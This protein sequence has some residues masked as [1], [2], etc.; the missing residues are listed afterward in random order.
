[1][2]RAK[3]DPRIVAFVAR[4]LVDHLKAS[5]LTIEAPA[6]GFSVDEDDTE[7]LEL[8]LGRIVKRAEL[9][10]ATSVCR[11]IVDDVVDHALDAL[12]GALNVALER[13]ADE[14]ERRGG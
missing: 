7:E 8:Q 11:D 5:P 12:R 9:M 13:V 3:P 10:Q 14:A 1:M 2:M 6:P 4:A